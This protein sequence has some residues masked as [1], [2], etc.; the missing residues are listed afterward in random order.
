MSFV[1][2]GIGFS[3]QSPG[4]GSRKLGYNL[5]DITDSLCDQGKFTTLDS[6]FTNAKMESMLTIQR[7]YEIKGG[8]VSK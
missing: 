3:G 2:H 4:L 8:S 1:F 7:Y 5:S 6:S